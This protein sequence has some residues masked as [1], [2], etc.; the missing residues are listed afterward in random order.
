M[1]DTY[2]SVMSFDKIVYYTSI[3]KDASCAIFK[4]MEKL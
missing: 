2:K 4:L 3:L 1:W